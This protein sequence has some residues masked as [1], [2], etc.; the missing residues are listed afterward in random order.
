MQL[1]VG[2]RSK[3]SLKVIKQTLNQ[4][5][6]YQIIVVYDGCTKIKYDNLSG[7]YGSFYSENLNQVSAN[8]LI[9]EAKNQ[10]QHNQLH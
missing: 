7:Y 2:Q 10:L 3:L 6:T 1:I 5:K 9:V 4:A 8:L